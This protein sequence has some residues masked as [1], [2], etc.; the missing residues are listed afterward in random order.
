MRDAAF[1]SESVEEAAQAVVDAIYDECHSSV[2]LARVFL[3]MPFDR[4]PKGNRLFLEGLAS[5]KRLAPFGPNTQVLTL[6]GSRGD[7]P[8]WNSRHFSKGH[9]GIPLVLDHVRELPMI[10]GLLANLGIK[11]RPDDPR[12]FVG[13]PAAPLFAGM[14]L[15]PDARTGRDDAGRM[16]IPAQDFVQRHG[17][18]TVFGLGGLYLSVGAMLAI[19]VFCRETIEEEVARQ[20]V[21]FA[22]NFAAITSALIME[23]CVFRD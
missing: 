7:L 16:V 12:L 8:E 11:L 9:V 3:S 17:I 20:L 13:A 21:P 18:R 2:A 1:R 10:G 4:L 22:S 23:D 6:L 15:V 14:F 19:L 5:S